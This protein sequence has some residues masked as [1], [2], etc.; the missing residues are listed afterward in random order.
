ML[1]LTRKISESIVIGGNIKL[2]ILEIR[3]KVVR[4]GI[5]APREVPVL[6][7]ELCEQLVTDTLEEVN[8]APVSCVASPSV[9]STAASG[10]MR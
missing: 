9:L 10:E 1:V 2:E 6:R 3:G 4:L 8:A 7:L 5:M